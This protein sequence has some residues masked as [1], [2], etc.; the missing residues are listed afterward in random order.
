MEKVFVTKVDNSS[1]SKPISFLIFK[2]FS[3]ILG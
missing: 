1:M 3:G 2:L